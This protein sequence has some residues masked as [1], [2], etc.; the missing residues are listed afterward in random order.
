MKNKYYLTLITIL[1]ISIFLLSGCSKEESKSFDDKYDREAAVKYA[2]KYSIKRNPDFP[3]LDNNCTNFVSQCLLAGGL[4]MDGEGE[5]VKDSRIKFDEDESKWYFKS[6]NFDNERPSNY[7]CST[8]FMKTD[9]LI[10]YWTKVRNKKHEKITNNFAGRESFHTKVKLGD[11][12]CLYDENEMI[13]HIGLVT[14]IE[15]YEVYFSGN[16]ND[17]Q[18][19]NFLM[20]SDQVYPT[21]GILHMD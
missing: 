13:K 18:N 20:L 19:K 5:P 7:A 1:L 8:S 6:K 9:S 21:L 17:V 16:T 4:E 2:L 3:Y 11:I 14:K 10:E 15:G 12:V